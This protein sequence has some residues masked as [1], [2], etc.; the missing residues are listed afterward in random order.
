VPTAELELF[1]SE[2]ILVGNIGEGV[3]TIANLINITRMY[4]LNGSVSAMRR[5]MFLIRDYANK[6]VGI[7]IINLIII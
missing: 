7:F 2:A 3:K 5:M 4:T 1:G 6:R